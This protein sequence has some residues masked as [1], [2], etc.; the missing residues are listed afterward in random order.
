[1]TA[2]L[3]VPNQPLQLVATNGLSL[4][5]TAVYA[6]VSDAVAEHLGCANN[7]VDVLACG[8]GYVAYSIFDYE[9]DINHP[10]MVALSNIAG[11]PFN[12]GDEE[13]ALR[14]PVLV[15]MA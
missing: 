8:P 4:P 9:G 7:L 15:V 13:Q 11:Y 5:T 6:S 12:A 3:Y 10:A 14:G 1:M 2:T